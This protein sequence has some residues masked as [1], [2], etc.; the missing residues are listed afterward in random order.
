MPEMARL[1]LGWHDPKMLSSTSD[2]SPP[3]DDSA[4]F[5]ERQRD[6]GNARQII[7]LGGC[8]LDSR[9]HT[10]AWAKTWGAKSGLVF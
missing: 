8:L 9:T 5:S 6:M 3:V 1:H 4:L 10:T 2:S 7:T